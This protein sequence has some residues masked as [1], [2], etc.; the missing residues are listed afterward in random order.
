MWDLGGEHEGLGQTVEREAEA[1]KT[2][3]ENAET[4]NT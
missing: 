4:D 2:S 3:R 1:T